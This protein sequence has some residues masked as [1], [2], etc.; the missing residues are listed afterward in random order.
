MAN[1]NFSSATYGKLVK[2]LDENGKLKMLFGSDAELIKQLQR[3]AQ[4]VETTP[5]GSYVNSSNTFVS[6]M[7]ERAKSFLEQG[8]N[9]ITRVP[10]ATML[11]NA[12]ADIEKAN[13]LKDSLRPSAGIKLKGN[14]K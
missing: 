2:N 11:R 7:G 5:S 4:R 12:S 6:Q 3:T 8:A 9:A 13:K 1:G 14:E 10:I